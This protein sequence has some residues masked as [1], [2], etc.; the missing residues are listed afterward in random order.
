M[1]VQTNADRRSCPVATS[2]PREADQVAHDLQGGRAHVRG[3][4]ATARDALDLAH[5]E[6]HIPEGQAAEGRGFL[7]LGAALELAQE[8]DDLRRSLALHLG[9]RLPRRWARPR[10]GRRARRPTRASRRG[11]WHR[12]I[13]PA[14]RG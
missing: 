4:E 8:R 6:L 13:A 14:L 3:R 7:A 1:A 5:G 12:A 11:G 9:L 10:S 2:P